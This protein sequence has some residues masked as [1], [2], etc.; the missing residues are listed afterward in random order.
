[1]AFARAL[2][3]NPHILVLDEVGVVRVFGDLGGDQRAHVGEGQEK[4]K[5][6]CASQNGHAHEV[7]TPHSA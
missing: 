6:I 7:G 2:L 5:E 1:M 3:K 4:N